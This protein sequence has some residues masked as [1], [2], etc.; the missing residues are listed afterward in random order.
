M[1]NSFITDIFNTY[2]AER[3][4]L[5]LGFGKYKTFWLTEDML[6]TEEDREAF[7][8]IKKS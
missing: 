3:E 1:E 6:K 7:R 2:I 8:K 5:G 4:K